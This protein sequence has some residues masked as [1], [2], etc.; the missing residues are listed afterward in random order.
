MKHLLVRYTVSL[1]LL[2]GASSAMAATQ[3]GDAAVANSSNKIGE[4]SAQIPDGTIEDA[5]AVLSHKS[6]EHG[7]RYFKVTDIDHPGEGG[8]IFA[9]ADVYK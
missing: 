1:A 2:F 7:G 5:I 8:Q 9:H 3:I 6:D 4:V